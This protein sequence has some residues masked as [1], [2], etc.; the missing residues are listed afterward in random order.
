[1][2]D[3]INGNATWESCKIYMVNDDITINGSLTIQ[4]GAIVKFK[5]SVRM[6]VANSGTLIAEGTATTPITFTSYKDDANGGDTNGDGAVSQPERNDWD[7]LVLS[8]AIG[9]RFDYC[10][11]Y[12][13]GG[14]GP[15]LELWDA[16]ASIQHCTFAHNSGASPNFEGALDASLAKSGTVI[17]DNVFFLNQMPM[18]INTA[19]SLD[20]SN[21]FHNPA[22]MS[23]KNTHNG[24]WLRQ[25]NEDENITLSETEVPFVNDAV[26]IGVQRT[27]TLTAGVIIKNRDGA[28]FQI[29]GNGSIQAQGTA[30]APVVFTSYLDDARGGDTNANGASTPPA[31]RDWNEINVN[32]TEGSVFNYCE[33][34]Y[35][36][37][38]R[39]SVLN[40]SAGSQAVITNSLFAYNWGGSN[41]E[42]AAAL[43]ASNAEVGTVIQNNTFYSNV[44]P[45]SISSAFDL[46]DSNI[47]HNPAN[48]S[49]GNTYDAIV[50]VWGS[51]TTKNTVKWEEK[52]VA[53]TTF[54]D[55]DVPVGKTLELGEG[56]V[57][58][59]DQDTHVILRGSASRLIGGQRPGV[60][61]TS[62]R[63]DS[64]GGDSN[65]NGSLNG[66]GNGEWE[67]IFIDT[68]PG[69]W[70]GWSN[71][72][73]ASH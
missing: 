41:V 70:L 48:P 54:Y 36:G 13:G 38:F 69:T 6:T 73:Y 62:D 40:L 20:N 46:D 7:V 25:S 72:R 66:P 11:F 9:S 1:V 2:N 3:D 23:Q 26:T 50:T 4:P 51:T 30:S 63:D 56:V 17:K 57:I 22:D 60:I 42:Y 5:P 68:V 14:T 53:F 29:N 31:S 33:F 47:F 43:D 18:S 44:R 58:K 10:R 49:Q 27:I 67:G 65:G 24:I 8:N 61:F 64:V 59:F 45:L 37:E 16:R 12:Y 19:I 52:E 34:L 55:I 21:V 39:G 71:I 15:T 35:G 28:G 32:G